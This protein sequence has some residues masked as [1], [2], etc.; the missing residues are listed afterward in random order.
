[1]KRAG[2]ARSPQRRLG[3]RAGLAL[4]VVGGS[5]LPLATM[6]VSEAWAL[7][8]PSHSSLVVD[9]AGVFSPEEA[10][11]LRASLTEFKGRVG[12]QLQ[13]LTLPSLEG[14]PIEGFSIRVAEKWKVGN[15]KRDDGV[16]LVVALKDRAL[17]IEVGQGLE[18]QLPDV[19]AGRIIRE[20]IVPRFKEGQVAVGV[21]AGLQEIAH[22]AGGELANVP[23]YAAPDQTRKS[24]RSP[25][26]HLF[27]L[28][29]LLFFVLPR[30][31]RGR[32]STVA[33]L[34]GGYLLGRSSRGG[35]LF[36]G[37]GGGFGGGGGGGFSGGGSSGNW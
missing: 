4:L 1:M 36:G 26:G 7:E 30:L 3:F 14:E 10:E 20:T 16:I 15:A 37:G 12:P 25:M 27:W 8:I 33:G 34:A 31:F 13:V 21:V 9:E 32:S 24:G 18:G 17:R 6:T 29:I 5:G 22:Y 2:L 28:L 23:A 19:L 11:S 35:G